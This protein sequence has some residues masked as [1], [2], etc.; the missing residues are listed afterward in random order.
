[1]VSPKSH[2]TAGIEARRWKRGQ[3]LSFVKGNLHLNSQKG[4]IESG[5]EIKS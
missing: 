1:M 4:E 3:T 5:L 2:L